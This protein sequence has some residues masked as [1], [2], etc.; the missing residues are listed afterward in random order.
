ML[1]WLH[2]P[3][4]FAFALPTSE[5]EAEASRMSAKKKRTTVETLRD[6]MVAN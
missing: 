2:P 6:L 4:G 3:P 5:G 1:A